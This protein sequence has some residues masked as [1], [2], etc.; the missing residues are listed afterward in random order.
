[1][2]TYA[3]TGVDITNVEPIKVAILFDF[4]GAY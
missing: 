1:M 3:I 4:E 2:Q